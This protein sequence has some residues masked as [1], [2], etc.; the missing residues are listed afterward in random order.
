MA[1]KGSTGHD[2]NLLSSMAARLRRV[3]QE[4]Q[5]KNKSSDEKD[6]QLHQY[7]VK[8]GEQEKFIAQLKAECML[9]NRQ[10]QEM[11]E[12]LADYGMIWVGDSHDGVLPDMDQG[13]PS[14]TGISNDTWT[15]ANSLSHQSPRELDFNKIVAN[16]G[17]LNVLCGEGVGKVTKGSDGIS[18]VEHDQP[19]PI[20]LYAN[21]IMLWSGPFRPYTDTSTLQFVKDLE[22]GYFP[23]ELQLRYPNGF[24]MKVTD[25]R[26]KHYVDKRTP[27]SFPG[28]GQM[29]SESAQELAM[30][31]GIKVA[32]SAESKAASNPLTHSSSTE[33]FLK[34]LPSNVIRNG[35]IID[36]RGSIGE[37][38]GRGKSNVEIAKTEVIQAIREGESLDSPIAT[39]RI[40]LNGG[41]NTL[42]VKLRY[43]ATIA[44]IRSCIDEHRGRSERPYQVRST[45]PNKEYVN[46]GETL[47]Q[48]SLV[49]SAVLH[50]RD[51]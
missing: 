27:L 50:V 42:I 25:L 13:G 20:S 10:I 35:R 12:F 47:E 38:V 26:E 37:L 24:P 15:Q 5:Q 46:L 3:E 19:I 7:R 2:D 9:A 22:D 17:D 39:L 18:R 40:K 51:M 23:S 36:V 14:P 11:E 29:I 34:K 32:S 28:E 30:I 16:I 41:G 49:P 21:G 45:F 31:R 1:R 6:E 44:D 43:N 4:L 48:A 8:L 33:R